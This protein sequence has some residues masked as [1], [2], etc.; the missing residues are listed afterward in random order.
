M[1]LKT[2]ALA[3]LVA[4]SASAAALK[5]AGHGHVT[6]KQYSSQTRTETVIL[7][8]EADFG[9]C[10]PTMKFVTVKY[11]GGMGGRAVTD[12]VFLPA[13][14]L[15]AEGQAGAS[16][17]NIIT[18]RICDNLSSMC[19]A[20][21]AA[22]TLCRSAQAKIRALGTSEKSTADTWNTLL[23]FGGA[24]EPEAVSESAST[25]T[26]TE[27]HDLKRRDVPFVP[28]SA[29]QWIDDCTGWTG[30][31]QTE[32][33][34]DTQT[35]TDADTVAKRQLGAAAAGFPTDIPTEDS[36]VTEATA[37]AINH[38]QRADAVSLISKR[39][40]DDG[41]DEE[42][43]DGG[44]DGEGENED[45]G[46]DEGETDSAVVKRDIVSDEA[47]EKRQVDF[48]E[49]SATQWIDDCTGWS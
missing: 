38:K 47:L 45:E 29:S 42:E 11:E 18:N 27:L 31:E 7:Q 20:N 16:N 44:D 2:S 21:A 36:G 49:C 35:D 5:P 30:S 46:E 28:C 25:G 39:S 32:P 26:T 33:S 1:I 3:L 10:L 43:D 24:A 34:T 19:G 8:D 4:G 23:G 14:S 40:F 17:P 9:L 37:G 6:V 41:G 22:Q 48:I 13:D 12:S 15:C